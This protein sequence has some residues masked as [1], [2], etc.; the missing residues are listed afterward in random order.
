MSLADAYFLA[1][2]R[3]SSLR[4][5]SEQNTKDFLCAV[6]TESQHRQRLRN[7]M[8]DTGFVTSATWPRFA[9][10]AVPLHRLEQNLGSALSFLTLRKD[11]PHSSQMRSGDLASAISFSRA[12]FRFVRSIALAHASPQYF[13]A[14]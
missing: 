7:T 6:K 13:L 1:L 5:S 8:N 4:H 12:G 9:I 3:A 2:S 14:A 10:I 11:V